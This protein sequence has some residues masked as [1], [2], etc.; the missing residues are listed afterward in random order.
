MLCYMGMKNVSILVQYSIGGEGGGIM[1]YEEV[2]PGVFSIKIIFSMR[3]INEDDVME[4]LNMNPACR[5]G[6]KR[7]E[8]SSRPA[9]SAQMFNDDISICFPSFIS[10]IRI[11]LTSTKNFVVIHAV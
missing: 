10:S 2:D 8:V 3:M 9:V 6:W 11:V 1:E 4:H 5:K 7:G